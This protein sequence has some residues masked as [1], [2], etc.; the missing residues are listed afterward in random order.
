MNSANVQDFNFVNVNKI[1]L[2]IVNLCVECKNLFG[3]SDGFEKG[4]VVLTVRKVYSANLA[5]LSPEKERVY[6]LKC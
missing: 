4:G 2:Q 1:K 3:R 5:H 6:S